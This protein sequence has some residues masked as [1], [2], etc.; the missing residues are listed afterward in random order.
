VSDDLSNDPA[1][2]AIAMAAYRQ[3][4]RDMI[5]PSPIFAETVPPEPEVIWEQVCDTH[6]GSFG[7]FWTSHKAFKT[8]GTHVWI[9]QFSGEA[10]PTD[11]SPA[12]GI[13]KRKVVKLDRNQLDFDGAKRGN[14]YYFS[15]S[16]RE[17][18]R[19]KMEAE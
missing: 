9:E 17:R 1:F 5:G 13:G 8:S 16:A 3:V 7:S 15:D 14:S 10:L 11:G 12:Y 4:Q 19:E 18:M 6:H 2:M